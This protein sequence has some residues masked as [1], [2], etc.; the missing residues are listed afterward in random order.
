[1]FEFLFKRQGDKPDV[2]PGLAADA[3]GRSARE[4]QAAALKELNGNEDGAVEFVLGSEFSDLRLEAAQHI[5][6]RDKLERAHAAIRNTDRRVAK[7]LQSRLDALRHRQ[8]EAERARVCIEQARHL[9]ADAQLHPNQVADLDRLWSVIDAPD[10][11]AEFQAVRATLAQR[12]EAQVALQRS[13]LDGLAQMRA[14]LSGGAAPADLLG[15]ADA[16]EAAAQGPELASLPRHLLTDLRTEI[17]KVRSQA[18]AAARAQPPSE[19]AAAPPAASV[20][21]PD[22]AKAEAP[23]AAP[24]DA[25]GVQAAA[26]AEPA[27]APAPRERTKPAKPALP[28]PDQHFMDQVAAFEASLQQGALH[29]AAELDK[30]LKDT[31]NVRLGAALT[32]RLAHARAELKRLNDWARWGGNISREELIRAAE[33]LKGQPLAM[34]ELAQKVGSLRERWKKLDGVSGAAPKSLWERFDAAC[35]AAYAPAAAH[36]KQLSE[37]RHGNAAKG[38]ALVEEA[39]REARRFEADGQHDWKHIASAVQRLTQAWMHLGPVDRKEK[40]R[41]DAD[42][43]RALGILEA[44]LSQR[45]ADEAVRREELI[46]QVQAIRPQDR[47]ALDA[48]RTAQEQW[49]H[50]AK[51]LPL[52]RKQE[53]ALWQRFRAAC[54]E[55]FNRRKESAHAADAERREHQ[56]AKEAICARLEVVE[57]A[58]NGQAILRQAAHDW[59]AAGPVPRA[60]E[61]KLEKRYHAAVAALQHKME[62]VRR[63]AS[64]AQASALRDKLRLVLEAEQA[65]TGE[66]PAKEDWDAR[67]QA[68]PALPKEFDAVLAQRLAAARAALEGDRAG[69]AAALQAGRDQLLHD[70]L[71]LEILAGVDSGAEFAR[72]RLKLQVEVL[73]SSLKSGQKP[74]TQSTQFR[75]LLALPALADTRTVARLEHLYPRIGRERA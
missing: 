46:A 25:A 47:H 36:F 23:S 13:L 26:P 33:Q 12:L 55:V 28:P 44:P 18:E 71:K 11:S 40:K 16:L 21:A 50:A 59:H 3:D 74:G 20:P 6:S 51:A 67:W 17:D 24:A 63:A 31:K 57:D 4:L 37:E 34:A 49:Q 5:H 7:L 27:P 62:Q 14:Q 73:Q 19:E 48:L 69:Y 30:A 54:D 1:M 72:D 9:A 35:T 39:L 45:R 10:Q 15:K 66:G 29:T 53:Q 60:N 65:V 43:H 64:L 75:D 22:T 52:E 42:F 32:D 61:A 2:P 68:I 58:A 38:Q 41:L 56:H 8:A 70:L